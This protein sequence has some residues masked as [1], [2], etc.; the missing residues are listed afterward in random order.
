MKRRVRHGFC[1]CRSCLDV[2]ETETDFLGHLSV[3]GYCRGGADRVVR[4][5]SRIVSSYGRH[6]LCR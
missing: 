1:C 6:A 2:F 5:I 4:E 3:D